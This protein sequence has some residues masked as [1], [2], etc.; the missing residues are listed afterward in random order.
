[1]TSR[2]N[3]LDG[4]GLGR[5]LRW[6]RALVAQLVGEAG[7]EDVTQDVW[8]AATKSRGSSWPPSRSWLAGTARRL[9][10]RW[11]RDTS[12]GPGL[13]TGST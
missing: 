6:T 2:N 8:L 7:I 3:S 1:M 12:R 9:A 5:S 10:A 13:T 11:W 4:E